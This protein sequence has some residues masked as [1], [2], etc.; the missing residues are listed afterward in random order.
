MTVGIFWDEASLIYSSSDSGVRCV[1]VGLPS[2]VASFAGAAFDENWASLACDVAKM[3]RGAISRTAK[4]CNYA[5]SGTPL[6][7]DDPSKM[8]AWQIHSYGELEDLQLSHSA[9]SPPITSPDEVLIQILATSVNPIDLALA[10]GYGSKLLGIFRQVLACNSSEIIEFPLIL[11]RDFSGRVISKG[12]GVGP[13]LK[14]GDEVWGVVPPHRQGCHAERVVVNKNL[15]HKK[16]SNLTSVEAGSMLYTSVTAW[17]ALK[18]SGDLL[19]LP[20][21]GK[22]V[23]VLG[24]SGGVGTAAIQMLRAWGAHVVATC[25]TDATSLVESLGANTVID[26]T[27]PDSHRHIREEGK[28]DIILDTA[29]IGSSEGPSYADCLKD[30][31]LSKYITL[32]SP[33]LQNVDNHGPVAGMVKNALDLIVPNIRTGL[34]SGSSTVRWGFFLP[35][36]QSLSEITELTEQGKITPI[37]EKVYPFTEMPAAYERVK[38]GHLRGKI[39]IKVDE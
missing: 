4:K 26:Y 27:H 33:L 7:K 6:L 1:R 21:R 29:G 36:P 38:C 31:S 35:T 19:F 3:F 12:H 14:L 30:W 24:G 39:A 34:V 9:R 13:D 8:I 5:T 18:V 37:V 22:R 15:L 23:L 20:S 11:G 28:Y 10:R 16:P 17:A 2:R 32:T 25:S